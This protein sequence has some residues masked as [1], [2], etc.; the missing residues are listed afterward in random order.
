MK[1]ESK[2]LE[3]ILGTFVFLGII[4]TMG[5]I[6]FMTGGASFLEN[7]YKI[8]VHIDNIGDLKKGAPVKLGGVNIG[9][10]DS[11]AIAKD[12]IQIV[13]GIETK[14]NLRSD[15]EASIAT[16][17]LVGDSFLD[18]TRGKSTTY[19]KKAAS[20]KDA[21]VI[22]GVT[23]ASMAEL[24]GQIQSIGT[25]VESMVRNINKVIGNEKFQVN[26][27]D[28]MGNVNKATH[29]AQLL[30]ESLRGEMKSV[31]I[32]VENIINITESASGTMKTIDTFVNKTIGQPEKVTQINQTID[33]ISELTESL[34]QNRDKITTTLTN[35]SDT[36]GNLANITG[37]INPHTGILRILSDEQAGNEL[38]NTIC[39]VQKA[40]RS[41]ATIGLTDLLADKLAAD[42]IFAIWEKNHKFSDAAEMATKWKEW[43]AYQKRVNNSIM[44][45]NPSFNTISPSTRIVKYQSYTTRDSAANNMLPA[46]GGN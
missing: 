1:R 45:R 2:N 20:V 12:S 30:I 24:L 15:T 42:K 39:Q 33:S 23:Q 43:M 31:G 28:T 19:I 46:Y 34:A 5:M 3:L 21:Q 26:I 38:M 44:E 35:I 16:A 7:T 29:Q 11:I 4:V 13:A 6:L 32:A 27:E 22:K 9:R 41:L 40:A 17:G 36:T 10:V 8:I 18:L 25:E 14:Y 37:S